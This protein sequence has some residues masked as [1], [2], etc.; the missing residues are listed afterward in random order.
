MRVPPQAM[1]AL[2]TPFD[3]LGELDEAAHR[4]NLR[5]LAERG[6]EGFLLGGSTGEGPYL[7]E[8][9]RMRLL[10]WARDELGSD[11]FLL[12]GIAAE[13]R[14]AAMRQLEE[15]TDGGA[16]AGLVMTPTTLIRGH[17]DA[18]AEHY[19]R[20]A[21]SA[22]LPILIYS[23]PLYTAYEP[24]VEVVAQLASHEAI[25]GMKDSGGDAARMGRIAASVPDG[26]FLFAGA[27]AV[28]QAALA[29][30]AYGAITAS[31]NYLP[32]HVL[33]V[34][35]AANAAEA[36]RWQHSL[37]EAAAIIEP[38]R[39]PGVKAAAEIAGLRPGLP[40]LPLRPVSHDVFDGI[41]R[42]LAPLHEAGA[43]IPSV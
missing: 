18:V 27:T 1:P 41:A 39:V 8:G 2:I 12:C 36:E 3:G 40:R 31:C 32:E 23:V 9:E 4:H 35:L 33:G 16:D 30:G 37:A 21:D 13:T 43:T 6:I 34:T 25:A 20:L 10:Q 14:R 11:P 38:H 29:A 42:A 24:P 22:R 15:A 28:L 7:E 17:H 5:Q 26:F 19:R